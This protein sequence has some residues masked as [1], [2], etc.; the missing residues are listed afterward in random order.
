MRTMGG[1]AAQASILSPR[2][3]LD[4]DAMI[5][6]L[7]AVRGDQTPCHIKWSAVCGQGPYSVLSSLQTAPSC[8]GAYQPADASKTL[9]TCLPK[10]A[11][12]FATVV[13]YRDVSS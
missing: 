3:D 10:L 4:V 11:D 7:L 2:Q 1:E 8:L 13:A 5:T 9:C 12:P 6:A